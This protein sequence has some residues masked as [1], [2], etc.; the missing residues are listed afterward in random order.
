MNPLKR[1][2]KRILKSCESR[3]APYLLALL[4]LTES[5]VFIIPP[6]TMLLPMTLA[7]RKNVWRFVAI[8]TFFSM[9]GAVIGYFIGQYSW[10]GLQGWVF[11]HFP[12]FETHFASVGQLF[13][14]NAV[15]A[16]LLAAITPIPY[17]VFTIAAGVYS[18]QIS[19]WLVI[20]TCLLGRGFRY[21]LLA[22]LVAI[23]GKKIEEVL[24]KY[25]PW[26]TLLVGLLIVAAVYFFKGKG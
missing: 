19:L 26:V 22:G 8:T 17:K 4:S 18:D 6:E 11:S 3:K 14:E 20:V 10:I 24:E 12:S 7:N 1:L 13:S 5:C 9:V 2:Y 25:F 16:L 23:F 21:G 15:E